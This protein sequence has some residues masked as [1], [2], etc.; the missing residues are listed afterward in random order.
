MDED[1]LADVDGFL[2]RTKDLP[3]NASLV[4]DIGNLAKQQLQLE[5]EK[6]QAEERVKALNKQIGDVQKTLVSV[7]AEA[8]M[9]SFVLSS[10]R[11]VVVK[12]SVSA[13][14]RPE[15]HDEAIDY[16][17]K[18]N[19]APM[20][21]TAV[22][23]AFDKTDPLQASKAAQLADALQ[24]DGYKASVGKSIHHSTLAAFAKSQMNDGMP[25]PS[26]LFEVKA[27]SYTEIK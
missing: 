13:K 25:L 5:A 12:Q 15:R 14:I 16:L 6:E 9:A 23:V 19:N 22:D 3:L 4:V 20:L 27:Y 18:S 10:G 2:E 8:H 17:V 7:M 21:R 24:R 11:K 1:L 26:D